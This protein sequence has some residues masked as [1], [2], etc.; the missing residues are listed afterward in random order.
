MGMKDSLKK[1]DWPHKFSQ[2]LTIACMNNSIHTIINY[3]IFILQIIDN[4]TPKKSKTNLYADKKT[5][6]S[7]VNKTLIQNI[8]MDS[9]LTKFLIVPYTI[10]PF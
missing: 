7:T 6:I 10:N 3:L 9:S 2:N 1:E 8:T 5:K 4:I